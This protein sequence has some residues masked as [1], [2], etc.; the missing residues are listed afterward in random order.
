MTPHVHGV[1]RAAHPLTTA[2]L[3]TWRDLAAVVTDD[4]PDALGHLEM[5]SGLVPDGP[6]V[7]LRF[8]TTAVDDDAVRSD[9][10]ARPATTLHGLLDRLEGNVE[11]HAYL[12]F[13][14]SAALRAVYEEVRAEW[15]TGDLDLS[16]RIRLG[17]R[18]ARHVVTWRRARSRELLEPV[19]SVARAEVALTEGEHTE[20]RQA[21]LVPVGEVDTV[22]AAI[23]GL[24]TAEEVDA[25]CVGPLPAYSFLD[26][27]TDTRATADHATA[28]RWGW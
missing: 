13:D 8:G 20:E 25:E 28:S 16:E 18:V 27:P 11:V 7:P 17:E 9:V 14:E 19:S 1:V 24:S 5:L 22:R 4:A 15:R 21:F 10:L 12:R 6:V 3:V 26:E 23:A 2:R